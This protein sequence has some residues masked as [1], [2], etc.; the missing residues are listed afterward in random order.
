VTGAEPVPES[1]IESGELVALL[2]TVI[3]PENVPAVG[4][5][6]MALQVVACPTE[7]MSGIA[8]PL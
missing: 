5:S 7:R 2:T 3:E 6:K 1:A 8:M 4:G